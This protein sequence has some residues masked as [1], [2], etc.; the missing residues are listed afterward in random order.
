MYSNALYCYVFG[1]KIYI[2]SYDHINDR[3]EFGCYNLITG[4]L[5]K[6][7]DK[8]PKTAFPVEIETD[9]SMKELGEFPISPIDARYLLIKSERGRQFSILDTH[10]DNF[11][12][13]QHNV[14]NGILIANDA[15]VIYLTTKRFL[16]EWDYK[17]KTLINQHAF[18]SPLEWKKNNTIFEKNKPCV[19]VGNI[20][21]I[22]MTWRMLAYDLKERKPIYTLKL[23]DEPSFMIPAEKYLLIV[24]PIN[25]GHVIV[26]ESQTGNVVMKLSIEYFCNYPPVVVVN[27]LV[28]MPRHDKHSV[29]C[30]NLETGA[31]EQLYKFESG[32]Y[33]WEKLG[34]RLFVLTKDKKYSLYDLKENKLLCQGNVEGEKNQIKVQRH[35][36]NIVVHVHA[37]LKSGPKYAACFWDA[38]KERVF[39][40][41]NNKIHFD[42]IRLIIPTEIGLDIYNLSSVP[43][44]SLAKKI[45]S[46]IKSIFL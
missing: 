45:K 44:A 1:H 15:R 5:L 46:A 29:G 26:L 8:I 43:P 36:N 2:R 20:F 6:I 25:K 24:I 34:D 21:I 7:F 40:I 41:G 38:A 37:L 32:I 10:D 3:S 19:L 12:F 28:A 9:Y 23:P 17:T 31:L 42:G 30:W 39:Y 14:L 35:N 18:M 4:K 13:A 22:M 33:G 27:K 16:E 11:I